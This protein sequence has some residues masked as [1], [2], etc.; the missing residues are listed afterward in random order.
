MQ[1]SILSMALFEKI[2]GVPNGE[3]FAASTQKVL[4]V[5][6]GALVVFLNGSDL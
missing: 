6:V 2:L 4:N 5:P 1:A 3:R